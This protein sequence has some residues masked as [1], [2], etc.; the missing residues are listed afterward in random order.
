MS[1]GLLLLKGNRSIFTKG[2][3]IQI[4]NN[5]KKNLIE[6][7]NLKMPYQNETQLYQAVTRV[8]N[9]S[10]RRSSMPFSISE[11]LKDDELKHQERQLNGQMLYLVGHPIESRKAVNYVHNEIVPNM[12]QNSQDWLILIENADMVYPNPRDFPTHFYFQGL[13]GLFGIPYESALADLRDHDIQ[14]RI[15]RESGIPEGA[16]DR[17]IVSMI[18]KNM[19]YPDTPSKL[20]QVVNNMSISLKRSKD[21]IKRL[22]SMGPY[23]DTTFEE[24]V[25]KPW[26]AYSRE[27]FHELLK[28]YSD[29]A[30]ILVSVKPK[31][32]VVF[33]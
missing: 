3:C 4:K 18:F 19:P 27:R 33:Q 12:R 22:L 26:H 17:I 14:D 30:S 29:K 24:S 10:R 28:Q 11:M 21:Y 23:K 32:L 5:T 20:E 1:K 6:I 16:V 9:T 25:E 15:Q 13:A 31:D 8:L 7:K 2:Y